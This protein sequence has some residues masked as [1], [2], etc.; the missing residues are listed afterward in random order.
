[1][2]EWPPPS[3]RMNLR[4]YRSAPE[5]SLAMLVVT[6]CF[7]DDLDRRARAMDG[8]AAWL[9]WNGATV[10]QQPHRGGRV[11]RNWRHMKPAPAHV[12]DEYHVP[13]ILKE[14]S[15]ILA[16]RRL[17]CVRIRALFIPLRPVESSI[18]DVLAKHHQLGRRSFKY[19]SS[20]ASAANN[21][22]TTVLNDS[23]PVIH[24]AHAIAIELMNHEA[25]VWMWPWMCITDPS[26]RL[27]RVLK[28]I[29]AVKP[30]YTN[31]LLVLN[32]SREIV[33]R[34]FVDRERLLR[35][36]IEDDLPVAD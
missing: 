5:L 23:K 2:C 27:D 36:T 17:S 1:M 9:E 32:G 35:V 33:M 24:I 14:C 3:D 19:R 7:P 34:P 28:N 13:N 10:Y 22:R 25:P 6:C 20:G 12:G 16:S 21:V 11:R 29:E 18:D 26:A 8:F 4:L 15:Y 31:R 30:L